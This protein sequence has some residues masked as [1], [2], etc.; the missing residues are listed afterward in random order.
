[1]KASQLWLLILVLGVTLLLTSSGSS[2]AVGADMPE[3]TFTPENMPLDEFFR[4][5]PRHASRSIREAES[6]VA[7]DPRS[8][9]AQYQLGLALFCEGHNDNWQESAAAFQKATQ[10]DPNFAEAY[11]RLGEL[12]DLIHYFAL[13][14]AHPPEE[15]AAFE[16]A[17]QLRPN[18][19]APYVGLAH[20]HQIGNAGKVDDPKKAQEFYLKA[21]EVE[22][23]CI[24][25]Y[26]GLVGS[27]LLQ[28]REDEVLATYRRIVQLAPKRAA[29]YAGLYDFCA[30]GEKKCDQVIDII[31][32]GI[33]LEPDNPWAYRFLGMV[34]RGSDRYEEAIASYRQLIKL[35]PAYDEA[36]YELGTLYLQTGN[37][38]AA[39][40]EQR[41]L[42]RL[43]DK[44]TFGSGQ[45]YHYHRRAIELQD[46][47]ETGKL[48]FSHYG[49]CTG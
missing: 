23:T 38:Q 27:Y 31:N 33:A 17:I 15:I 5:L 46:E 42:E 44:A 11:C 6:V 30:Y 13:N 34:Y 41:I 18:Y 26:E 2:E 9:E 47:I 25:A 24:P 19:A 14:Y 40:R 16:K 29:S 49:S 20:T 8:A 48:V 32:E 22:P 12:Y 36:H 4:Y 10:L 21:I 28:E 1:M 37:R 45:Q 43:A 7:A 35:A 39:Q 3:E